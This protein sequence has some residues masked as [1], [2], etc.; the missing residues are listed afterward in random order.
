MKL[1]TMLA[2]WRRCVLDFLHIY[3]DRWFQ[4][5]GN[6]ENSLKTSCITRWSAVFKAERTIKNGYND[7]LKTIVARR[8]GVTLFFLNICFSRYRHCYIR[9]ITISVA[10]GQD[11]TEYLKGKRMTNLLCSPKRLLYTLDIHT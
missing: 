6:L 7:I 5:Q 2:I 10:Q 3:E 1:L 8:G 11:G 9:D 4:K